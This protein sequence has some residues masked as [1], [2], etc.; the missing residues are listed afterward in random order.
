[1]ESFE[2][3]LYRVA[4]L[5]YKE[6]LTQNQISKKLNISRSQISRYLSEAK[7]RNIVKIDITAPSFTFEELERLIEKIYLIN[8]T[9][10]VPT[11]ESIK[12]I[13]KYIGA[14][15][16]D[17]L[18]RIVKQN[19]YIAIG[20]GE[21]LYN[22]L[23]NTNYIGEL[24]TK[25]L[26]LIG[27][28]GIVESAVNTNNFAKIFAEKTGGENYLIHAS[29]VYD[30]KRNRDIVKNESHM[31][32]LLEEYNKLVLALVGISD[33]SIKSTFSKAVGLKQVDID[34]LRNKKIVGE[35]NGLFINSDGEHIDNE[36]ND[37]I[38]SISFESLKSINNV[39][40]IAFGKN[41]VKA[42][43]SA[44][45]SRAINMF[46]TDHETAEALTKLKEL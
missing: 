45:K 20:W 46:I 11:S 38:L 44:L 3:I 29:A 43:S 30:T 7:R 14:E 35:I 16:T 27:G 28:L 22:S 10:I 6:D 39:I 4:M 33:L 31:K 18:K 40:A 17:L 15:L 37:R 12:E 42:I 36:M 26:P 9:I 41:K 8:Q 2:R 23:L 25:V 5:Y 34:N 13:Y 1:M 24:D 19:D 21:T 32:I